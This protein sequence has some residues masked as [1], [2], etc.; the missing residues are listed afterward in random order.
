MI[1][2]F[3]AIDLST[4]VSVIHFCFV[5]TL[6]GLVNWWIKET[7]RKELNSQILT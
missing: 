4:F 7:H 3:I 1:V 2:D 5:R 6:L